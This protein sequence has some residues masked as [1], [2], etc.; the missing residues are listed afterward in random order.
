MKKL[1]LLCLINVLL[2][3]TTFCQTLSRND[4]SFTKRLQDESINIKGGITFIA[5]NILNRDALKTGELYKQ[6][7]NAFSLY[8]G[9]DHP[10]LA[11]NSDLFM[12][13]GASFYPLNNG[14]FYMDYIDIDD[15]EGI[16]GS[17]H[18][19]SSSKSRL[20]MSVDSKVVFAGLYWAGVYPYN[21]WSDENPRE[22]DF[23][24]IKFKLPG[25]EYKDITGEVVN[26]SGLATQRPYVCF[27]DVTSLV[28]ALENPNG[29][30]YA[31][32]IRAT[33][34]K[35]ELHGIGGAAG[36]SLVIVYENEAE[37]FKNISIADGFAT[38]DGINDV[39]VDFAGFVT[40]PEGNVKASFITM[41]LEGDVY[42]QGDNLQIQNINGNY[43][44]I[45]TANLNEANNF[46]N[47]T[48]SKND[49][50]GSERT[51]NSQNTLGFDVD[52][53]KLSENHNNEII[54]NNTSSAKLRYTTSGDV[55][56]PFFMAIAVEVD[57]GVFI[58]TNDDEATT[59]ED[60]PVI[61]N[62]LENDDK[63]PAGGRITFTTPFNGTVTTND[64][65]TEDISDD[66]ISYVPDANFTGTDTFTYTVC[67]SNNNQ[68]ST[69]T[70]MV[71]ITP[72]QDVE[73]SAVVT[74]EQPTC[75]EPGRITIDASGGT[76]VYEY[77]IVPEGEVPTLFNANNE[78]VI[79]EPGAYDV[80]VRDDA[81]NQYSTTINIDQVL[82]LDLTVYKSYEPPCYGG[83]GAIT[84]D[85]TGGIS[86]YTVD[87][88]NANTNINLV[89][90]TSS[91]ANRTFSNIVAGTYIVMVT[92]N[93]GCA[94]ASSVIEIIDPP[95]LVA[96]GSVTSE[97][98]IE[99]A[100]TGGAAPYGYSLNGSPFTA[101]ST[102]TGLTSGK[103]TISVRDANGCTTI[104]PEIIISYSEF[105]VLD[106]NV[107]GFENTPLNID[108]LA[109]DSHISAD[110]ILSL[111]SASNGI[112][113]I[114][115]NGTP[116]DVTD[117]ILLYYPN[118]HFYGVDSFTY[119]I[120]DINGYAATGTVTINVKSINDIQLVDDTTITD[121]EEAVVIDV[122]ANDNNL[123]FE[124][125]IITATTPSNGT[126]TIDN[127][128]TTY[129]FTDDIITYIPNPSFVGT[130]VFE[131]T[132]CN[133]VIANHCD[134]ATVTIQVKEPL[135]VSTNITGELALC[136]GT[137]TLLEVNAVRG[138]EA[139]TY[140][141]YKDGI[142][143]PGVNSDE[144]N[145]CS[146][147]VYHVVVN[148]GE[149]IYQSESIEVTIT[150]PV[151]ISA[152]TITPSGNSPSGI[153]EIEASG[154]SENYVYS[155]DGGLVFISDNIFTDLEPGTYLINVKDSNGC[156]SAPITITINAIDVDN[157]VSRNESDELEVSYKGAK[158]YQWINVD[159]N[160]EI[161]DATTSTFTPTESGRYQVKIVLEETART[162]VIGN[163]IIRYK[164]NEIV[165]FSPIIE[166]NAEVLN[167]DEE[168]IGNFKIYPNPAIETITVPLKLT[169]EKYKIY[170]TLGKEID[171]GRIEES[172]LRVSQ[173]S[174]GVYL[175]KVTGY[176]TVRF[177]KK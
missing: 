117:D 172:T 104:T 100:V 140:S 2:I 134:T 165:I 138:T 3:K 94:S 139:Y 90:D 124:G 50:F 176:K 136:A 88:I 46:F 52:L 51:I 53:F 131:Y 78:F 109:N 23:R 154:G 147:G 11:Y 17:E 6:E 95:L 10:N 98:T 68:C 20:S 27:K 22:G 4:A 130:D 5:N 86:P 47:S 70:V 167:V 43:V 36:W 144:V 7:E 39:E 75:N 31:A 111:S 34:G 152:I 55:Y 161:P 77:A 19:F 156:L 132:V 149:N 158:S 83:T 81:L 67:N 74:I 153:I 125:G 129:D 133:S 66:L 110:D 18:T 157:S 143:I 127:A 102:F 72:V 155:I 63:I 108:V 41:A 173:L 92:D 150:E 25:E 21:N 97:D 96:T 137:C 122:F 59:I 9:N 91:D 166:F 32:N 65:G 80:Y 163:T 105:I 123:P 62:V 69:G 146:S 93:T 120:E 112:V 148:D 168:T 37:S 171:K 57:N 71:T 160:T 85:I 101:S 54:D 119:E 29:D 42:I 8:T 15:A 28:K 116:N 141:F 114:N 12:K 14:N 87:V 126:V 64:M 151:Q 48:I 175:L 38:V 115:N 30:Y 113:E 45:S 135:S 142:L 40:A 58:V 33:V 162:S 103:Y 60:E 61:I 121:K 145:I 49:Q 26:D 169:G 128:G 56:W 82:P 84:I 76:W 164:S 106:D 177:I 99:V 35:D 170:D 44:N 107:E 16:T 13:V 79:N 174:K 89:N 73:L 1:L 24:V 118:P 159:T